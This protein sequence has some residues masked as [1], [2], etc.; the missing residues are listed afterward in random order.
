ML[1]LRGRRPTSVV[2][3]VGILGSPVVGP[4]EVGLVGMFLVDDQRLLIDRLLSLGRLRLGGGPQRVDG[5]AF[6]PGLL[7]LERLVV[8]D[9]L[10]DPFLERHHCQLQDLHRLDHAGR[11]HLLLRHPHFLAERHPHCSNPRAGWPA[12]P[13]DLIQSKN[14]AAGR[15][16]RSPGTQ[17]A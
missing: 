6:L 15:R 11:K 12:F 16:V 17:S 9:L 4:L 14:T 13:P 5:R 8:L 10:F 3:A 1:D 7:N 2:V